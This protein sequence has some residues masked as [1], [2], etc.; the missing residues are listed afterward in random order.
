[1]YPTDL[2]NKS[3]QSGDIG[4]FLLIAGM[5]KPDLSILLVRCK[6]ATGQTEMAQM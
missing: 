1:M 6:A 2:V 4:S 3:R 5:P